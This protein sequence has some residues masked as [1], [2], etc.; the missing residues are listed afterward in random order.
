MYSRLV[1]LSS[2]FFEFHDA[3]SR[4]DVEQL[5]LW[6]VSRLLIAACTVLPVNGAP[7]YCCVPL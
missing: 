4:V 3:V 6:R 5:Q 2:M 7:P 1:L